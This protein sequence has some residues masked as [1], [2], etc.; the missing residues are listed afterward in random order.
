MM[1]MKPS[2][3]VVVMTVMMV[4]AAPSAHHG[5]WVVGDLLGSLVDFFL[6]RQRAATP[7]DTHRVKDVTLFYPIAPPTLLL[8]F[9]LFC[10]CPFDG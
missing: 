1:K 4:I 9:F 2:Q 3:V 5:V 10:C 8:F 7:H 6:R